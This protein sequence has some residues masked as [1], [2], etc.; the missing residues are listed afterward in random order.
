MIYH[1]V[2]G[3]TSK[4]A[5][6]EVGVTEPQMVFSACYGEPFLVCHPLTYATMLADKL[7]KF[8]ADAWLLNT[9]WIGDS[10]KRCPIKVTRALIDAIHAGTL[11]NAPMANDPMFGLNYPIK[12]ENVPDEIL[13]P[14]NNWKDK[15]K[16]PIAQ[17]KLAL[18]FQ[19]AFEQK[20]FAKKVSPEVLAAGPNTAL[21][22]DVQIGKVNFGQGG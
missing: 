11:K 12:C 4:M 18:N 20:G 17:K 8:N 6:T 21:G 3:F 19:A 22:P 2:A 1:F 14:I 15:A 13:Q 7:Q 5:G 9:G 10:G 16:Y